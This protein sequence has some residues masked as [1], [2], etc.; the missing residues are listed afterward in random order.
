MVKLKS[1]PEDFIVTE[2]FSPKISAS[3]QHSVFLLEKK[4]YSTLKAIQLISGALGIRPNSISYS[5]TK[6]KTAITRQYVSVKCLSEHLRKDFSR[7][8]ISLTYVGQSDEIISLGSHSGNRFD[9]VL[10]DIDKGKGISDLPCKFVNYF[11]EQRF[12][13]DN[14]GIGLAMLKGDFRM[15]IQKILS[16]YSDDTEIL[17]KI[18]SGHASDISFGDRDDIEAAMVIV[19]YLSQKRNDFVGAMKTIPKKILQMYVKS[20]QSEIFN[21]SVSEMISKRCDAFTIEVQRD[22][23]IDSLSV[24]RDVSGFPVIDINVPIV[25]FSTR[26]SDD[27]ISMQIKNQLEHYGLSQ[28]SFIIRQ[29]PDLSEE[30][31]TRN[32]VAVAKS[33]SISEQSDDELNTGKMRQSISFELDPGSYATIFIKHLIRYN[34]L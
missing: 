17:E 3:G 13:K 20:L 22:S 1:I 29:L 33:I 9:I 8:D 31:T 18:N 30:G 7:K 28:R 21:R 4:D 2:Q 27:D 14:V 15:A 34:S 5:G 23:S 12:S 32:S 10:R 11:D 16:F 24:P 6:D 26:L 25:G 19:D